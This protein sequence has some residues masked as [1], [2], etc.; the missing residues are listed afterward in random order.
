MEDK[1]WSRM[2]RC[3]QGGFTVLELMIVIALLA[4]VTVI[5]VPNFRTAIQNN[6]ITAQ[7]NDLVT[8]FQLAR[9]E[10]VKR[11]RPVTVCASDV[12]DAEDNGTAPTCDN[13]WSEGW[14]VVLDG[15]ASAG[16]GTVT[17]AE[18][19][20]AWRPVSDEINVDETPA[21]NFLRFLPRGD[22]DAAAGFVLPVEIEVRIAGC[23]GERAR[24]IEISRSGTVSSER[25]NCP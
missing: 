5:A 17:V 19:I 24:N 18:R 2:H 21:A 15:P 12:I 14:M 9:S 8:A 11:G 23:T 20:R 3:R 6:R 7:T 13:D 10:A 22:V 25:V 1:D 16:S 4:I